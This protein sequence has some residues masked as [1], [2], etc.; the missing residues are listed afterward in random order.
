MPDD[1]R[2]RRTSDGR[3]A[4]AIAELRAITISNIACLTTVQIA[5][6]RHRFRP[7]AH[8]ELALGFSK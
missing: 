8:L 3:M 5:A 4:H 7:P 2:F 6:I 1:R